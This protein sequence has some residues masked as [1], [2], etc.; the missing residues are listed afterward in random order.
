MQLASVWLCQRPEL[1]VSSMG[2]GLS[3]S[4]IIKVYSGSYDIVGTTAV[5][6]YLKYSE[7]FVDLYENIRVLPVMGLR[8][9]LKV[10]D[11]F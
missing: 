10:I 4:T 8:N 1:V 9:I 11:N 2:L 7:L 6:Y 3:P 5:I